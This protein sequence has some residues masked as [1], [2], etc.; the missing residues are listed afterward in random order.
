MGAQTDPRHYAML[1]VCGGRRRRR[2]GNSQNLVEVAL[3]QPRY[4]KAHQTAV[5][6]KASHQSVHG[7]VFPTSLPFGD[8][9]DSAIGSDC[10]LAI[11]HVDMVACTYN[12]LRCCS[13]K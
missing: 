5:K 10:R 6:A 2:S 13:K 8:T 3:C 4:P 1:V 9:Q 12:L 7:H 11:N